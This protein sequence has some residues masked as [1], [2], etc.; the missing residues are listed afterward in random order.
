MSRFS[1]KSDATN[2]YN[3]SAGGERFN[4]KAYLM[5]FIILLRR[6]R[7]DLSVPPPH[8]LA[9]PLPL[10]PSN[11]EPFLI[12]NVCTPKRDSW[13]RGEIAFNYLL[14]CRQKNMPLTPITQM[15]GEVEGERDMIF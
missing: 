4:N 5:H 15:R 13:L 1:G 11:P 9:P 12:I 2:V 14:L 8:P 6:L 7:I 10:L 3:L